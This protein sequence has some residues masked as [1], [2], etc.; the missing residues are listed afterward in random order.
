VKAPPRKRRELF[1]RSATLEGELW[2]AETRA[3]YGVEQRIAAGG[4]PGTLTEARARV[5][6][7]LLPSL[8]RD[9]LAAPTR[10]ECEEAARILYA[11]AR[12]LWL[13][14]REREAE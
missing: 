2:A 8:A 3:Q 1:E 7:A 13:K 14:H 11:S 12:N 9:G 10:T 6:H 4:W 5:A